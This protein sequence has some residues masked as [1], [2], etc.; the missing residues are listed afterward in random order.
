MSAQAVE[1]PRLALREI[2]RDALRTGAYLGER[3]GALEWWRRPELSREQL[4]ELLA[5]LSAGESSGV[6][7]AKRTTARRVVTIERPDGAV[8]V[9]EYRYPLS[10][11]LRKLF[12]FHRAKQALL[13]AELYARIGLPA[14]KVLALIEERSA[15]L[16][17]RAVLIY[18][19]AEGAPL[20]EFVAHEY[21][22]APL[23]G[24][25]H[26][27]KRKLL[28]GLARELASQHRLGV[29]NRD[30]KAE[31]TLVRRSASER[32]EWCHI[33]LEG[34]SV[35]PLYLRALKELNLAQLAASIGAPLRRADRLFF[36]RCY[37]REAG[38]A[39][40][41][42]GRRG[43]MRRVYEVARRRRHVWP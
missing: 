13:G 22:A 5:R 39:L 18:E 7:L 2:G 12:W 37:L 32:I 15:G 34:I 3:E 20:D 16:V 4:S 25:L 36:L 21:A 17:A 43:L 33:D 30:R 14:P 27:E 24:A 38:E 28:E 31:N 35:P 10:Q 8:V 29:H 6:R 42:A 9:K 40:D 11:R 1:S 26:S 23:G 19:R 41:R